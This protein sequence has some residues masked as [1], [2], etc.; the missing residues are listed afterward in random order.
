MPGHDYLVHR[1]EIHILGDSAWDLRLGLCDLLCPQV[2]EAT[3]T[4][5]ALLEL[6]RPDKKFTVKA[7][8]FDCAPR[9]KAR[10]PPDFPFLLSS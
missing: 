6:K 9:P 4:N 5:C 1:L 3:I 2:Y 10:K 7:E 8:P